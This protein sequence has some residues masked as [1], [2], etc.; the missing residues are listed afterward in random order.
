MLVQTFSGYRVGT[1]PPHA[2]SLQPG[3]LYVEIDIATGVA[4][5]LWVGTKQANGF[6]GNLAL[7]VSEVSPGA[8]SDI[9]VNTV[10]NPC[11]NNT[12]HIVGTV[13]PGA[14][15]ELAALAGTNT[16]TLDQL[17]DWSPYDASDGT[18]DVSWWLPARDNVRVRV[19]MHD[20]PQ[21]YQDSNLFAVLDPPLTRP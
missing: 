19:R 1:D 12:V 10:D 5:R 17:N 2:C 16:E 6:A 3:E 8:P 4:P 20:D 9:Q 18:F 13:T 11:E 21:T 15:I 7:V 14:V